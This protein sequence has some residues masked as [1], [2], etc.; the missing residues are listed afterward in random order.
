MKL[1]KWY[2]SIL[3]LMLSPLLLDACSF[4]MQVMNNSNNYSGGL[5]SPTIESP[6]VAASTPTFTPPAPTETVLRPTPTLISIREGT[7][8][9]LENF[10][11]FRQRDIVHGLAFTPD[12]TVLASTGGQE[13]NFDIYLWDTGTGQQIGSLRGH[14]DIVWDLAFSPD[15]Q[16]LAS[17][18]SDKTARVWNWRTGEALKTL[19]FPG[20]AASVSFSPDGRSLAVGGVDQPLNQIQNAAVWTFSTGSWEPLIKYPEYWN[21]LTLNYSPDGGTLVGGG[22]SRNVQVW[23]VGD[24]DPRFTLS[25]AHQAGK[26]AISPDGSSLATSTCITVVNQECTDAGFW[27]WDLPSGRLIRKVSGFPNVVV[28][29]AFT[30]D[31]STLVAGS[32]DGT[33]RFY[34]TSDYEPRFETF[35]LDGISAMALSADSGLLATGGGDGGIHLWKN[36]SHP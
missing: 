27:L 16:L 4:S 31:G 25:H 2:L 35:S 20:E 30:A 7:Y 5:P 26:A 9:M 29:L 36:I 10:M 3:A 19:D 32:R 13:E 11:N 34:S 8:A 22:T 23:N 33:M 15:G 1:W 24:P 21:I 28:N 14:T 18:S 12:G 17:V 6:T